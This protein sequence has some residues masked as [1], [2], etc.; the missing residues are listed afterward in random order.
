MG[1]FDRQTKRIELVSDK[2]LWVEIYSLLTWG[3]L[4]QFDIGADGS[5]VI[6]LEKAIPMLLVDW[7][8]EED[9][10]KVPLDEDHINL[11]KK[12]DVE[13]IITAV[14]GVIAESTDD[15]K[16]KTSSKK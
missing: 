3:E 4:K 13:A 11:L 12:P 7:N 5:L 2:T 9:D 6:P 14:N 10:K 1:Y 16:K 8:L 15:T